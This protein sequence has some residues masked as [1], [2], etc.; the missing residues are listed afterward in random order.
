MLFVD[1][2]GH[3]EGSV[4]GGC[5]EG[6][7]IMTAQDVMASN[8]PHLLT[9]GVTSEQAWTVG[10]ACGG[11]LAVFVQPAGAGASSLTPD[12]LNTAA[13][14]R[15][16]RQPCLLATTIPGGATSLITPGSTPPD[17]ALAPHIHRSFATGTSTLVT[18]EDETQWFLHALTPRPRLI[19]VGA[20]HIAQALAPIA[21]QTGFDVVIVDPRAQLATPAR[22]PGVEILT[23]WPDEALAAL[24]IDSHTAIVT[25]THDPKLDDPALI[26]ALGSTA[27]Y[28]GALGSRTTQASRTARLREL[29]FDDTSIA[30]VRGPV[31][32]AIGGIGAPEIALSV[33][34]EIVATRRKAPLAARQ[35][36]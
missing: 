23:D 15:T 20:V 3:V 8:T 17:P 19:V 31:G 36:W 30:R 35:G 25:L 12:L 1:A 14:L 22:F 26:A 28:I 27:F 9:Y 5:V 11:K 21:A 34:A 32:L 10:L 29:G 33:L 7:V 4:S 2:D 16:A 18:L 6:D 24:N 13:E